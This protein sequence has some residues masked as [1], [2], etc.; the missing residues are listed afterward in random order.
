MLAPSR[1][2]NRQCLDSDFKRDCELLDIR[3]RQVANDSSALVKR[4]AREQ[5]TP[6]VL[7]RLRPSAQNR[8]CCARITEVEVCSA[9][10]HAVGR[11]SSH[12]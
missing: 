6:F 11:V 3:K 2:R 9:I 1:F 4:F 10:L 5:G 12:P 7:S 8:L